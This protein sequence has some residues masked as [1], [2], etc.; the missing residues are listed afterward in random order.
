MKERVFEKT[1][2]SGNWGRP[3][4]RRG[5]FTERVFLNCLHCDKR[6]WVWKADML[7]VHTIVCPWCYGTFPKRVFW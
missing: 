5:S 3:R 1:K 2:E 6:I 4:A 7:D